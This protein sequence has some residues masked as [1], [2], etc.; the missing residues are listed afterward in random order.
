MYILGMLYS[1]MMTH[2]L[3]D[4]TIKCFPEV[5]KVHLDGGLPFHTLLKDV[6]EC[7]YVT[8]HGKT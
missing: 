1:C 5:N 7:E 4:N 3:S 6:S 2:N 8:F